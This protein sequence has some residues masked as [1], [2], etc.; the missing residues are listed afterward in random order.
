MWITHKGE[1]NMKE[2]TATKHQTDESRFFSTEEGRFLKKYIS[3]EITYIAYQF[4]GS[5][6]SSER[7]EVK[8]ILHE[9]AKWKQKH[10]EDPKRL[11]TTCPPDIDGLSSLDQDFCKDHNFQWIEQHI[12]RGI[13]NAGVYVKSI[14]VSEKTVDIIRKLRLALKEHQGRINSIRIKDGIDTVLSSEGTMRGGLHKILS[15]LEGG[16]ASIE[17]ANYAKEAYKKLD[18]IATLRKKIEQSLPENGE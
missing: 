2:Q 3:P 8:N 9:Y 13:D 17:A 6:E 15:E 10:E 14:T 18:E 7:D 1:N 11:Q 5:F 4:L 12:K 16:Y